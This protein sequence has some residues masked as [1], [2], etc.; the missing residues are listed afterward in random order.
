MMSSGP[1]C[2]HFFWDVKPRDLTGDLNDALIGRNT[3]A[4]NYYSGFFIHHCFRVPLKQTRGL[5]FNPYPVAWVAHLIK[6]KKEEAEIKQFLFHYRPKGYPLMWH[7]AP[8]LRNWSRVCC[9][10][11]N[12]SG[13][14]G[15]SMDAGLS[16]ATST[17]NVCQRIRNM[18]KYGND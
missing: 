15:G 10:H 11:N 5:P 17:V 7:D 2:E 4:E 14:R 8:F 18:P 1:N 3:D 6:P 16:R 13:L 9:F 12:L